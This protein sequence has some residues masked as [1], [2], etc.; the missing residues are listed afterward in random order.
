ME[1]KRTFNTPIRAPWNPV[2]HN[3]LKAIDKHMSLYLQHHD[4][5]HLQKAADLRQY[6]HELKTYI[7]RMEE[8]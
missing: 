6:V 4:P 2:I 1:E 3:L 7:H 8:L 5:W